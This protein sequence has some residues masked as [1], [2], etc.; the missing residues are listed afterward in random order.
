MILTK[1]TLS[2]TTKALTKYEAFHRHRKTRITISAVEKI[3]G[4]R[5][6]KLKIQK[7]IGTIRLQRCGY[8]FLRKKNGFG[9]SVIKAYHSLWVEKKSEI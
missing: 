7:V 5:K 4:C 2:K 6:R 9:T 3:I 8:I 1:A